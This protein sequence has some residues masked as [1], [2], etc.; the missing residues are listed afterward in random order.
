M[1]AYNTKKMTCTEFQAMVPDLILAGEEVSLH[2][3]MQTCDLCRELLADLETIAEAA[4]RLFPSDGHG[5][6]G[7]WIN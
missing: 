1:M 5:A 2:P 6:T 3:H 4:R 7:F